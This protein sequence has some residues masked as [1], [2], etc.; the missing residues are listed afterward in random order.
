MAQIVPVPAEQRP[1]GRKSV[2]KQ[3][4]RSGKV[5]AVLYGRGIAPRLLVTVGVPGDFEELTGFVKAHVIAAVNHGPGAPM[6][7]AA[8]VGAVIHW[9]SAIPALAGAT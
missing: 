9:E 3:V 7:A 2:L 5:P 8:D 1:L 4:R 6:L